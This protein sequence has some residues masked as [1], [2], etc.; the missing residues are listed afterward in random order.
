M[1][2]QDKNLIS[3]REAIKKAA[4]VFGGVMEAIG[5]L[6]RISAS[7]LQLANSTFSLFA[8]TSNFIC[9]QRSLMSFSIK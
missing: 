9:L 8:S 7:L 5:A 3:R 6:S 2:N 1:E 4:M